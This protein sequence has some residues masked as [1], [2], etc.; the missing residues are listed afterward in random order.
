MRLEP[1]FYIRSSAVL[2]LFLGT[3]IAYAELK[4][5]STEFSPSV[6]TAGTRVQ[7]F[8]R[9]ELVSGMLPEGTQ[10]NAIE[11]SGGLEPSIH[12]TTITREGKYFLYSISFTPWEPGAG[13]LPSLSLGTEILPTIPI[14][15]ATALE[16]DASLPSPRPQREP[17]GLRVRVYLFA[18]LLLLSVF[19]CIFA[20]LALPRI[21]SAFFAGRGILRAR[22]LLFQV[23]SDLE[24]RSDSGPDSWMRLCN[25]LRRYIGFRIDL[26]ISP[27]LL[28]VPLAALTARE[29]AKLPADSLPGGIHDELSA[30]LLRS[31]MVRWAGYIDGGIPQAVRKAREAVEMLEA[32]LS[33]KQKKSRDAVGG[34]R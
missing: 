20:A 24:K 25:A 2:L 34:E 12:E 31:D 19:T 16:A 11:G 14:Q 1:S 9:L 10:K 22:K 4:L 27:S 13:M 21:V 18:G 32:A 15:T 33:E 23:F 17:E 28:T 26:G 6:F 29:F 3:G 5:V 30:I 7:A 8:T